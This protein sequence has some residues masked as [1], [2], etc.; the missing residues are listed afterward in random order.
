MRAL[1][2]AKERLSR[3]EAE[4]AVAPSEDVPNIHSPHMWQAEVDVLKRLSKKKALQQLCP[5]WKRK[6]RASGQEISQ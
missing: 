2:E 4:Q 5:S 3:L 1:D 6:Y